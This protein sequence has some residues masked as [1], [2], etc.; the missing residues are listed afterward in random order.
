[1]AISTFQIKIC[2]QKLCAQKDGFRKSGHIYISVYRYT[3]KLYAEKCMYTLIYEQ[4]ILLTYLVFPL[5]SLNFGYLAISFL[6]TV[7]Y[8]SDVG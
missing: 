2:G 7:V 5:V 1:M 3:S 8:C 6:Q 4:P